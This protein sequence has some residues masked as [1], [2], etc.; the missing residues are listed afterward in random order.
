MEAGK[1]PTDDITTSPPRRKAIERLKAGV[2]GLEADSKNQAE[3]VERRK[4]G[5]VGPQISC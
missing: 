1:G 3:R 2:Q 4:E 5:Y